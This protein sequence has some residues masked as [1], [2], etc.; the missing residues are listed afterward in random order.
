VPELAVDFGTSNTVAALLPGPGLPARL[1]TF[2][3]RDALPSAVWLDH[4][5]RLLVGTAA[6]N[7][8]G[9]DPARYEPNPK[10]RIDDVQVLL[11]D[12]VLPVT[13][14]I[15]AVLRHVL[16]SARRV[17]GAPDRVVLTHPAD[18]HRTR[19]A[20]LRT[21]AQ[22]AGWTGRLDL[23]AEPVAAAA[24]FA[25]L[26]GDRPGT[27][28]A[29]YDM[30]GGTTDTAVLR[31]TGDGWQV[32]GDAGLPSFG[33]LDVDQALL[34]HIRAATG[35]GRPEWADLARPM[36]PV[37]R[38]AARALAV[39]VRAAKERLSG[40]AQVDVPLPPGLPDAHVTR[41]EL[42]GLVRPALGRGVAMLAS[43]IETAGLAPGELSGVYLVGGATRMPILARLIAER[44]GLVPVA[45]DRPESCVAL[46]ALAAPVHRSG[47]DTTR[48]PAPAPTG[49]AGEPYVE[50]TRP[51]YRSGPPRRDQP[52][53][54]GPTNSGG[55][56]PVPGPPMPPR[57]PEVSGAHQP[58]PHQP[59]QPQQ[60]T[61]LA[62]E[63]GGR[64]V[65]ILAAFAV[66]VAVAVV[67]LLLV[68]G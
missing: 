62:S 63:R 37:A 45:V 22:V 54:R 12:T 52:P 67:V 41:A 28:I 11:G 18:W 48:P 4:D 35:P 65:V 39:D 31:R 19:R 8:A 43:T 38:R 57:P 5:R 56:R 58:Q 3:H 27:A 14:L 50:L 25:G 9:L 53:R 36:S 47:A 33:G 26:P 29:V 30:G 15:A 44:V 10:R 21:A 20:T 64:F 24:Y 23:L 46:G 51:L 16:E 32:L 40:Y 42:E 55:H 1:L 6:E 59:S 68:H 34:E 61:G 49:F 17:T 2:D 7:A 13:D 66:V 60:S